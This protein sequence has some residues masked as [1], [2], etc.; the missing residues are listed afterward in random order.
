AGP[1]AA[2]VAPWIVW[3][4]VH[5]VGNRDVHPASTL[6]V[7]F[8]SDRI[9]RLGEA[10]GK[11]GEQL[12]AQGVWLWT[13]PAFLAV[14]IL[15]IAS[16]SARRLAGFYLGTGTLMMFG[17]FWV[18][19]VGTADIGWWLS[20]S[21]ARVVTGVVFVSAVG[22]A[23]LAANLVPWPPE[24]PGDPLVSRLTSTTSQQRT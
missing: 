19:W 22:L 5:G 16:G 2:G 9:G 13:V 10:I 12:A 21:A 8:L 14:S 4:S 3:R 15:C 23:H 17:L 7:S 18:Y 20:V 6:S 1:A 11:L 24:P